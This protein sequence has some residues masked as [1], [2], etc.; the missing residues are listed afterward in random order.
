MRKLPCFFALLVAGMIGAYAQPGS[1]QVAGE[2]HLANIKQLT[3][4]GE[5]AEAY[6]S[7]DG[8]QLIFQ[9][10]RDGNPCDRI[11]SMNIDGSNVRQVSNGEGRTTCSYFFK[12]GKKVLYASTHG[13]SRECPPPPDFSKYGYVWA[14]YPDYDI[15]TANPDGTNIQNLTHSPGYDAEATIS[16]NGK[17]IVFTSDRSGDLELYSMDIDGKNVKQLT[18]EPGYDGG[19]FYSPDNKWIVYRGSHPTDPKLIQKDKDLLKLHLIV[20]LTFEVWIMKADGSGKRQITHLNAA[21]FAPFFMP[22]GKRIIFCTNY[23]AT[24]KSKRNFDLAMINI[25]G[26]G[27][28]R[29]TYNESFDGFPMFSP[30]GKKLVFA[31]NRHGAKEGDTNVFIADWVN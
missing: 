24:D 18:N 1:L 28:E 15:Y 13:G 9:S 27:L 25:D 31:S 7:F 23:F 2:K 4:G 6:F 8:K 20:P 5:N 30:N 16:P 11:Y 21:S 12:G 3:F 19:A 10:K 17:K 26:T 29:I 22:D 14:V